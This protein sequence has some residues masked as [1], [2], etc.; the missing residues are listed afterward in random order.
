MLEQ[1][2]SATCYV[3]GLTSVRTSN[4]IIQMHVHE[5]DSNQYPMRPVQRNSAIR[6]YNQQKVSDQHCCY[7]KEVNEEG[8]FQNS[9]RNI[10]FGCLFSICNMSRLANKRRQWKSM[11]TLQG[12]FD[13]LINYRLRLLV[14]RATA[15]VI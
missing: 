8:T 3:F 9:T 4:K 6:L 1:L 5:R 10:L 11:P 14:S 13:K 12:W 15:F 2:W 7:I